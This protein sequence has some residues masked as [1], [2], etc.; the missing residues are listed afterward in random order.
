MYTLPLKE[1]AHHVHVPS[2]ANMALRISHMTHD[3]RFWPI[4]V[5]IALMA[6]FIAIAIWAG[7]TGGAPGEELPTRPF[8]P[9]GF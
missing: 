8:R 7:M 3:E 6:A 4:M 5:A 2:R 1:W 9:Y